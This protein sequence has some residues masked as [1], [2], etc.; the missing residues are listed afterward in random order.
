MRRHAPDKAIANREPWTTQLGPKPTELKRQATWLKVVRTIVA[1]RHRYHI[2][3]SQPPP[4]GPESKD[5][6]IK[7]KINA[8]RIRTAL[9]TTRSNAQVINPIPHILRDTRTMT[10]KGRNL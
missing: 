10:R 3:D 9:D 8:A 2:T 5:A 7:Q 6:A 4:P 1:Y